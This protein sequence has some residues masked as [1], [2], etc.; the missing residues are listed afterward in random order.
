MADEPLAAHAGS[1]EVGELLVRSVL[2][3]G[4]HE[5][6]GDE[7]RLRELVR[8]Y[9]ALRGGSQGTWEAD[10]VQ[11]FRALLDAESP[12]Y[13]HFR[14]GYPLDAGH[15]PCVSI[16]KEAAAEDAGGAVVGDV[17]DR[18][19]VQVG[20][21]TYTAAA[22]GSVPVEVP[23]LEEHVLLGCG[24]STTVQVGSWTTSPELSIL[25]DSAVHEVLFRGKRRLLASGV[26]DASFTEG[27]TPTDQTTQI[28]LRVGY[29]PIQRVTL[30][31]QRATTRRKRPLPNRISILPGE[32][33]S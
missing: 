28:E 8:R 12:D 19:A 17:I 21:Y 31:W 5:L 1:N 6:A 32:T 22:A 15:L 20:T 2:I 7:T 11:A 9:D 16:I 30:E 10:L 27:G 23:A 29:V 14:V 25:L 18:K 26:Y 4:L 13:L 3:E 24:Y 33:L